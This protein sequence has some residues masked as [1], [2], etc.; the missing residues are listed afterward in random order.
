MWATSEITLIDKITKQLLA[1][2]TS[3]ANNT[4]LN[5]TKKSKRFKSREKKKKE[6]K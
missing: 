2:K 4:K 3:E 5:S 6:R 1:R